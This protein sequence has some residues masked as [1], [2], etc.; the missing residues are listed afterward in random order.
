M[1]F[2]SAPCCV[3]HGIAFFC[4]SVY[5]YISF[6][7]KHRTCP[8]L[9]PSYASIAHF[10]RMQFKYKAGI[11]FLLVFYE[12]RP[13]LI[14]LLLMLIAMPPWNIGGNTETHFS[15]DACFTC[16]E[17]QLTPIKYFNRPHVSFRTLYWEKWWQP[18]DCIGQG[19]PINGGHR[20]GVTDSPS[21]MI[22]HHRLSCKIILLQ[23]WEM[24]TYTSRGRFVTE[25]AEACNCI[26][27]PFSSLPCQRSP[28]KQ[29]FFSP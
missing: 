14:F 15:L 6:P 28:P 10:D 27:V 13:I 24:P 8:F 3:C 19:F 20:P 25:R 29:L 5:L 22:I 21:T 17:S 16:W 12:F 9:P 18:G 23:P 11:S 4:T 1:N 2:L 7:I 26:L